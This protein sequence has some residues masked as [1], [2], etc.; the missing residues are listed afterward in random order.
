[1]FEIKQGIRNR[2]LA[3]IFVASAF[4]CNVANAYVNAQGVVARVYPNDGSAIY[5]RISNDTCNTGV[6]SQP[7]AKNWYDSFCCL[8][9]VASR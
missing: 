9:P 7:N 1:M 2:L 3:P 6:M 8:Y 5:F 4:S